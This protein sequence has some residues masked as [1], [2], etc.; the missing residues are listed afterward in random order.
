MK[1]IPKTIEIRYNSLTDFELI[2]E[3]KIHNKI[4]TNTKLFSFLLNNYFNTKK[5]ILSLKTKIIIQ[6]LN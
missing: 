5:E 3:I 6:K 1:K 2:K 4:K